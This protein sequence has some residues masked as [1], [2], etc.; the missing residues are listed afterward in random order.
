MKDFEL[1]QD[2]AAKLEE[3]VENA[4]SDKDEDRPDGD[5]VEQSLDVPTKKPEDEAAEQV[6]KQYEEKSGLELD[7]ESARGIVNAA[8]A[9][10]G[11]SGGGSASESESSSDSDSASASEG[12]AES[13]SE[14]GERS[15]TGDSE[16][17]SD[18]E[19]DSDSENE[20]VKAES[21]T[22]AGD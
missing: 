11:S 7:D 10:G 9:G 3:Q 18:A 22:D 4:A 20:S 5:S 6:Q 14:N 19:N 15:K 21:S 13:G 8:R 1:S 16:T 12:D 17:E 2:A